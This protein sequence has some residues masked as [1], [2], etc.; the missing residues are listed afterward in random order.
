MINL[1]QAHIP[2][3][4][5]CLAKYGKIWV[6]GCG[7][8]YFDEHRSDIQKN[9][10]NPNLEGAKYRILFQTG[11]KVPETVEELKAMFYQVDANEKIAKMNLQP[12]DKNNTVVVPKT[13][14]VI[15]SKNKGGRP[16]QSK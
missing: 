2:F 10:R 3:I 6:H 16:K 11:D 7:N 12:A 14:E 8:V 1:K 15:E 4:K 5:A 9:Y 13:E